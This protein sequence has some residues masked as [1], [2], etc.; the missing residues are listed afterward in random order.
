ME[1]IHIGTPPADFDCWESKTFYIHNFLELPDTK[2]DENV[3]RS[4]PFFC[5]GHEWALDVFPGGDDDARDGHVSVYLTFCDENEVTIDW[6]IDIIDSKGRSLTKYDEE[7]ETSTVS[8]EENMR[9]YFE[10]IE[11]SE[12]LRKATDYLVDG[13]L[14]IKVRMKLSSDGYCNRITPR[15]QLKDHH[16]IF[17]DEET[18]DLAFDVKGQIVV[19]HKCLIK[20]QSEELYTMCEAFSKTKPMPITDV[21][22][23]VFKVMLA[24]FYGRHIMPEQ[25]K[26]KSEA[27]LKAAGKYG[28]NEVKYEAEVW[29]TNSLNLTVKN[30]IDEF[31]KADGNNFALV[32]EA[33]LKF[34][35]EHGKEITTADS[36]VRLYE[37]LPLMKEVL[38]AVAD[39]NKKRKRDD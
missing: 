3:V 27:L 18:S 5:L 12:I 39:N 22:P 6:Q 34:I 31:L 26:A 9:G 24:T 32:R 33:A 35:A 25:W 8:C 13:A 23:A 1:C 17:L 28:F 10:F 16:I 30:V 37:S 20:S 2:G 36:F 21:E 19:A 15:H 38:A 29:Y 11:R 7:T 14:A 4:P